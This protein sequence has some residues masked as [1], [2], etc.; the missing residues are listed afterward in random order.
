MVYISDEFKKGYQ[1]IITTYSV[2]EK[3][4][5]NTSLLDVEIKTR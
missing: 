1:K 3:R 5:D 4:N 2:I